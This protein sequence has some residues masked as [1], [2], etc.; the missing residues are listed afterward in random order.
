MVVAGRRSNF[1]FRLPHMFCIRPH[2]K[3]LLCLLL[4]AT[5]GNPVFSK[6]LK[7]FRV[8]HFGDEALPQTIT[9]ICG[10]SSGYLWICTQMGLV[11]FDGL[12]FRTFT[13]ENTRQI[14]NVRAVGF[15]TDKQNHLFFRDG[16]QNMYRIFRTGVEPWRPGRNYRAGAGKLYR[17]GETPFDHHDINGKSFYYSEY[18]GSG[19]IS[20]VYSLGKDT[21]RWKVPVKPNTGK[22]CIYQDGHVYILDESLQAIDLYPGSPLSKRLPLAGDICSNPAFST[23]KGLNDILIFNRYGKAFCTFGNSIYRIRVV[24]DVLQTTLIVGNL[25]L[26]KVSSFYED[27][28]NGFY[29][30]GT[31][32]DGLYLLYPRAFSTRLLQTEGASNI[33]YAV[34]WMRDNLF[35]SATGYVFDLFASYEKVT[36]KSMIPFCLFRDGQSILTPKK[37]KLQWMNVM[38]EAYTI[39]QPDKTWLVKVIKDR[40]GREWLAT[41]NKVTLMSSDSVLWELSLPV[42]NQKQEKFIETIGLKNDRTLLIGYRDGMSELN[43]VTFK[44][45]P[46]REMDGKYIRSF[47][48]DEYGGNWVLTY[49]S[50]YY[51]YKDNRFV[52]M[53][54]DRRSYLG[55]AHTMLEDNNGFY[56]MT[57]NKGLFRISRRILYNYL[58]Q[59]TADIRYE[60]FNKE[61]GFL[62]NEFNGGCSPA[63]LIL[64][65]SLMLFPSMNGLVYFNPLTLKTP[66]LHHSI[67]IDQVLING[68]PVLAAQRF[69]VPANFASFR[70]DISSPYYGL[71]ENMVLEY[72][73]EGLT[74]DWQ[75]IIENRYLRFNRLPHGDYTIRIRKLTDF[76]T[77]Q[78]QELVIY[79]TVAVPWYLEWWF[80]VLCTGIV[81]CL[82]WLF[83]WLRL[84][85]LTLQK[86][87]LE[88]Q[89]QER[90][91]QLIST[92]QVL[93][94]SQLDL[95]RSNDFKEQLTAIVLH[96]IQTPLRFLKRLVKY[97]KQSYKQLP[98]KELGEELEDLY[99]STAEVAAYSEDFLVWIK[100]QKDAF[101]VTFVPVDISSLLQKIGAL[102]HRIAAN[103]GTTIHISC[104]ADLLLHTDPALISIIIR[105]L[106]DNAVKY[107]PNGRIDISGSQDGQQVV[108]RVK[109]NGIGMTPGQV[110]QIMNSDEDS[111]VIAAGKLG[112][113][114]IK[115][116]LRTLGGRLDIVSRQ[117]EGTTVSLYF[118]TR[119]YGG[120]GPAG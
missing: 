13:P 68:K 95:Q 93:E 30:I 85:L 71:P 14:K 67:Y 6:E 89:I 4:I 32:S 2:I 9:E 117:G 76:A 66:P 103:E 10:D 53:P 120:S 92:V 78:M 105:N 58:A 20:F 15:V 113:T 51:Y 36:E 108:I 62:T 104:P 109:D 112:Y 37:G 60:Y 119:Q 114:F 18:R 46:V 115:D 45:T 102:Y 48:S 49:G 1:G 5:A 26:S 77:G 98:E 21:V 56:W 69:S 17:L 24:D 31:T 83:V 16:G 3:Q 8:V 40:Q 42:S 79:L 41:I 63:G 99:S 52:K 43:M 47:I 90:T 116:L 81:V 25:N 75:P 28:V 57:T 84:R 38:T 11:R 88:D 106:M 80:L 110:G 59:R 70:C 27:E 65:D 22:P 55:T 64:R 111:P 86:K 12:Q 87:K 96:D 33:F 44:E 73:I 74:E 100:S 94:Q 23:R 107:A 82:V 72:K 118:T 91:N 35:I 97:L 50:G 61:N 34:E 7:D 39:Y 54:L 29:A 101:E 19:V